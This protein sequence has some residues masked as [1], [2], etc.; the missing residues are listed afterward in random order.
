VGCREPSVSAEQS[1]LVAA[2]RWCR[3]GAAPIPVL[4]GQKTP[5]GAEWQRQRINEAG[6][7]A[8]FGNGPVNVGVLWGPPSG[9][10]VDCDMD[11]AEAVQVARVLLPATAVWG[12]PGARESH[13]L[14]RAADAS[15]R[16]WQVPAA[17]VPEGRRGVYWA[18]GEDRGLSCR[19]LHPGG[20]EWDQGA[21]RA[22][23]SALV[24]PEPGGGRRGAGA[25]LAGRAPRAAGLSGNTGIG[26]GC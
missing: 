9:G 20:A 25:V 12:R 7:A 14:Y 5:L 16:K 11:W 4:H 2:L 6:C 3:R 1:V 21:S 26:L 19:D 10:L 22:F 24:R 15:T 18:R 17:L 23:V 13:W 8:A